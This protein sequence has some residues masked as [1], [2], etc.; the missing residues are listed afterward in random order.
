LI[1]RNDITTL[2]RV[3]STSPVAILVFAR[4]DVRVLSQKGTTLRSRLRGAISET[5]TLEF[6]RVRSSPASPTP[7]FLLT[8]APDRAP[9]APQAA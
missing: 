5:L 1:D 6:R 9:P 2:E 4:D 3:E 7:P 8:V